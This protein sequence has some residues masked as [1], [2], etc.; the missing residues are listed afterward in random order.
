MF[1]DAVLQMVG[2]RRLSYDTGHT[3]L[4]YFLTIDGALVPASRLVTLSQ[5]YMYRP[6][7]IALILG[8]VVDENHIV[9]PYSQPLNQSS[10]KHND[11]LMLSPLTATYWWIFSRFWG[12]YSNHNLI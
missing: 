6:M 11:I 4:V 3:E 2:V 7:A 10:G 12:D 1:H 5:Y 9:E 8:Y